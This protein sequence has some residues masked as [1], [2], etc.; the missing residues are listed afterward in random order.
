MNKL[1][2]PAILTAIVVVAGIFAF[3]PI[4]KAITVHT[5]ITGQLVTT[6]E[7]NDVLMSAEVNLVPDSSTIK[8][9]FLCINVIDNNPAS[10]TEDLII[11]ITD[12]G[13]DDITLL[14]ASQIEGSACIEF[15]GFRVFTETG[16]NSLTD[17]VDFVV[18]WSE[19]N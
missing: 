15:T 18:A 10:T 1:L 17:T 7:G 12:T 4:E 11:Q 8:K 5:Q 6:N 2:I 14:S 13:G 16:A 9:G 19:E 3:A